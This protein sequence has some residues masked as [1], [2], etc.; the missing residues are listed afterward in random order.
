MKI[1]AIDDAFK[2]YGDRD[3]LLISRPTIHLTL[4]KAAVV[5]FTKRDLR[6]C[7]K[8][9]KY[10]CDFDTDM[11]T[12]ALDQLMECFYTYGKYDQVFIKKMKIL[13]TERSK[14]D[15]L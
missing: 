5:T 11:Y 15:E 6:K 13:Q 4:N 14:Y 7:M 10:M 12:Y 1:S 2:I 9:I 8:F 3:L